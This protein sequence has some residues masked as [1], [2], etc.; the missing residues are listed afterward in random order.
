MENSSSSSHLFLALIVACILLWTP[1]W[2]RPLQSPV[3][4]RGAD[5]PSWCT[6]FQQHKTRLA[7]LSSPLNSSSSNDTDLRF[8]MEKRVV[9]TGPNPLHN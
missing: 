6:R 4:C 2:A 1:S 3:L 9:K 7:S 5:P 8:G